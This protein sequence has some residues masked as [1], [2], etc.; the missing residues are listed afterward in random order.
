MATGVDGEALFVARA[1]P[2][3]PAV[4]VVDSGDQQVGA[5]GQPLRAP[6]AAVV[7]DDGFNRLAGVV[8]RFEVIE[9]GGSLRER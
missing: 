7:T 3:E 4:L 5:T 6:F 2:A 8:V 1:R 9:G